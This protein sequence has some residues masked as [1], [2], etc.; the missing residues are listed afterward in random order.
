MIELALQNP[1]KYVLKDQVEGEGI[2]DRNTYHA[3]YTTSTEIH[4]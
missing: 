2:L 1:E 4:A 3:Y